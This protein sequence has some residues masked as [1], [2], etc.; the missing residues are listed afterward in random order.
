MRTRNLC[1]GL[2]QPGFETGLAE[3]CIIAWKQCSLADLRS[4]V[5]RLWVGDDFAGIF[6]RGQAPPDE[7]IQAKL[8]R[9][10]NFDDGVYRRPYCDRTIDVPGG[11]PF[12]ATLI[13]AFAI[14]PAGVIVGLYIDTEGN[15]HGYLAV[16]QVSVGR[17]CSADISNAWA[18]VV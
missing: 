13:D 4:V 5:K 8:F 14:N 9:P 15:F 12:N 18:V 6:E 1:Y 7:F 2:S 11:P 10:S 3:S 17:P 16:R